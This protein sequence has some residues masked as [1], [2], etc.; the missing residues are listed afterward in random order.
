MLETVERSIKVAAGNNRHVIIYHL[1]RHYRKLLNVSASESNPKALLPER[2]LHVTHSALYKATTNGHLEVVR[3]LASGFDVDVNYVAKDQFQHVK[4]KKSVLYVAVTSGYK[5]IAKLLLLNG[6]D[7]NAGTKDLLTP[8]HVAAH[9]GDLKMVK[10]LIKYGANVNSRD[11][12]ANETPLFDAARAGHADVVKLL[13]ERGADI[14]LLNNKRQ[15]AWQVVQSNNK[16]LADLMVK[17]YLAAKNTRRS[18]L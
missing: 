3:V 13:V 12:E 5:D 10:R 7:P 6:A 17:T 15:A 16:P 11:L 8:L 4:R 14:Y 2:Y 1:L 9:E 18:K